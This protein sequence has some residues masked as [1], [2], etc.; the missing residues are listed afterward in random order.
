M[1]PAEKAELHRILA[2]ADYTECDEVSEQLGP[3][4]ESVGA[5]MTPMMDT[6][7]AEAIALHEGR[8]GVMHIRGGSCQGP[9]LSLSQLL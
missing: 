2:G 3:S 1:N 6:V 4:P 9:C 8:E 5:V 7:S